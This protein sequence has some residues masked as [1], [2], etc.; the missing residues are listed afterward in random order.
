[1]MN[2][3]EI[4]PVY[5][6][7]RREK[8]NNRRLKADRAAHFHIEQ[9]P[10]SVDYFYRAQNIKDAAR[11]FVR[12]GKIGKAIRGYKTAISLYEQSGEQAVKNHATWDKQAVQIYENL[13]DCKQQIERLKKVKSGKWHGLEGKAAVA[14]AII[15]IVGGLF[16]LS[17]NITGNAIGSST[18]SSSIGAIFLVVGLVAGFFWL[19]SKKK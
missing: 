4:E 13:Y 7:I 9:E 10:Y 11:E 19:K 6:S 2:K 1:M 14:A 5:E 18:V 15:G 3:K 17:F 16:F 12:A 8:K